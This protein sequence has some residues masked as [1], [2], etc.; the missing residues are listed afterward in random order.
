MQ[1]C[2]PRV[3]THVP[4]TGSG[5]GAAVWVSQP[6]GDPG[7][8]TI[9]LF[10]E[11]AGA[12]AFRVTRYRLPAGSGGRVVLVETV[13]GAERWRAT[14]QG[15]D[16]PRGLNVHLS[17]GPGGTHSSVARRSPGDATGRWQYDVAAADGTTSVPDGARVLAISA[18]DDG[19]GTGTVTVGSLAAIPL[20]PNQA[21][22]LRADE[23]EGLVG[24]VDVA[25]QNVSQ[26]FVGWRL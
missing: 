4:A 18:V 20:R 15:A 3:V 24:P 2:H 16:A 13:P 5:S 8:W 14:V 6:P 19:S 1:L 21:F 12:G 11:L 7:G 22:D 25:F 23:L 10:A 17:A 26:R 9:D